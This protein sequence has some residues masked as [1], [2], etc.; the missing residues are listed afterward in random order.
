MAAVSG[1]VCLTGPGIG[2]W[3]VLA[4]YYHLMELNGWT[5]PQMLTRYGAS[6]R[7]ARARRSYDRIMDDSTGPGHGHHAGSPTTHR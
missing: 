6:A 3:L 7:G 1:H 4:G 2:G 5:S